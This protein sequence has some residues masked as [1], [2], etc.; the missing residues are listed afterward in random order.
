LFFEVPSSTEW[1][2]TGS[3]PTFH[4]NWFVDISATLG[5]KLQALEAY[6][7]ELREW[8]HPRS[9]KAVEHLARWRGASVGIDAAEAFTLGR[10]RT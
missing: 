2:V 7:D 3:A 10:H 1:Q 5:T 4:P 9:T 8:P 6:R